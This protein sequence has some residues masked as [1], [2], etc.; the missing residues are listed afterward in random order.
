LE[1]LKRRLRHEPGVVDDQS[2]RPY[3]CTA[4][5]TNFLTCWP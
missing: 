5:S 2:I 1:P 3:A 4:A